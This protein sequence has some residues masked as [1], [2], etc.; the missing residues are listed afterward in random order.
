MLKLENVSPTQFADFMDRQTGELRQRFEKDEREWNNNAE[1]KNRMVELRELLVQHPQWGG[2]FAINPENMSLQQSQ[3]LQQYIGW[4]DTEVCPGFVS[5]L[6]SITANGGV[7]SMVT[8]RTKDPWGVTDKLRRKRSGH[9]GRE[10]D[11]TYIL[12]DMPDVIGARVIVENVMEMEK[13]MKIIEKRFGKNI[14]EKDDFY[15]NPSKQSR[16]PYRLVTY[17]VRYGGVPVEIQL[18]TLE[19]A[20]SAA[21][22]HDSLYKPYVPTSLEGLKLIDQLM[23]NVA[24]AESKERMKGAVKGEKVGS[25]SGEWKNQPMLHIFTASH[26]GGKCATTYLSSNSP[27]FEHDLKESTKYFDWQSAG[28]AKVSRSHASVP[29]KSECGGMLE[30]KEFRAKRLKELNM[31]LRESFG[32]D[33]RE[34]TVV[35][36]LD[37]EGVSLFAIEAFAEDLNVAGNEQAFLYEVKTRV[38]EG[39]KFT[40]EERKL[41][42]NA[43]KQAKAAHSKP[44]REYPEGQNYAIEK[45]DKETGRPKYPSSLALK[46]IPYANHCVQVARIGVRCGLSADAIQALLCH[47][48]VEDTDMAEDDLRPFISERGLSMVMNVTKRDDEKGSDEG[49]NRYM[50]RVMALTDEDKI[51]KALDREHNLLRAFN[52]RDS[53][54]YLDQI[55]RESHDVFEGEFRPNAALAQESIRFHMLL[56]EVDELRKRKFAT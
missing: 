3:Q 13:A 43:L 19:S 17:T 41:I 22:E 20:A 11:P 37:Q 44:R 16:R 24:V 23:R 15:G 1:G 36:Q 9:N 25:L 26:V 53:K 40:E 2:V 38:V 29:E 56:E 54:K 28:G 5:E 12:A 33:Y 50:D 27:S 10:A 6:Q 35:D 47:D 14:Y 4:L 30:W 42:A 46:H 45:R 21:A 34:P 52:L 48:V 18:Q 51:A 49:R 39:K 31:A 55:V 8:G 7:S 32:P